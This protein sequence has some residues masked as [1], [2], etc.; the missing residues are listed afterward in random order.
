MARDNKVFKDVFNRCLED[1]GRLS[2]GMVLGPETRMAETLG[3]SRTTVRA[4]LARLSE[5]GIVSWEGR[6]K[7][8][9]RRPRGADRFGPEE[10]SS[11]AGRIEAAFMEWILKGDLAPGTTLNEADLARRF[12]VSAAALREFLIRFA[13]FGLISK[14]PNRHWVLEGFTRD[15]AQE[16]FDI[17]EMYELRAARAFLDLPSGHPHWER[18]E[19]VTE[20]HCRLISGETDVLDFPPLDERFHRMICTAA[21]NRFITDFNR[22]IAMVVHY[23]YRWNKR[24]EAERNH[25]AALEHMAILTALDARDPAAVLRGL[26]DHLRTARHTLL[27]SVKWGEDEAVLP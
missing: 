27:R 2:P 13:R 8:L 1:L 9:L 19:Q 6:H 10:T 21:G 12:N 18:L 15:F 5:R 7:T 26:E 16:M 14:R 22:M 3:V 4:V 23:H 11:T 20:E 17:R 25:A 24:D